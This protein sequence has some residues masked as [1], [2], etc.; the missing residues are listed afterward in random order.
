[1][2][3]KEKLL[4][5]KRPKSKNPPSFPR[6]MP[7][8][9]SR[10]LQIQRPGIQLQLSTE[11]PDETMDYLIDRALKVIEK[12]KVEQGQDINHG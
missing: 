5:R 12:A 8:K 7:E 2:T 3:P 10:I 11:C 9:M 4:K 6:P 1:M